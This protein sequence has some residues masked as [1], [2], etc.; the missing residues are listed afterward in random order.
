MSGFWRVF[1]T[2]AWTQTNIFQQPR[3]LTNPTKSVTSYKVIIL[4][5]SSY[6]KTKPLLFPVLPLWPINIL[7]TIT[8]KHDW[9]ATTDC[10]VLCNTEGQAQSGVW[11]DQLFIAGPADVMTEEYLPLFL[12]QEFQDRQSMF[13]ILILNSGCS[14]PIT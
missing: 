7:F 5:S 11:T 13:K 10:D 3:Q 1:S 6:K 4:P 2:P 14:H 8:L 9:L 12:C